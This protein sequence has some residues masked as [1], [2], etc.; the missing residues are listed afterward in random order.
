M[1]ISVVVTTLPELELAD[2]SEDCVRNPLC[3]H[4]PFGR[5]DGYA[6]KVAGST[7]D[8]QT[9]VCEA[10]NVHYDRWAAEEIIFRN[11]FLALDRVIEAVKAVQNTTSQLRVELDT[12]KGRQAASA[13][14]QVAQFFL[15]VGYLLTLAILYA[16]KKC[17]Q[18]RARQ[19]EEEVKL[20][21]EKLQERKA[22][23]RSA[24]ARAKSG[25]SPTQE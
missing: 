8:V 14:L 9:T 3:K 23:R 25:P 6:C 12:L 7:Q 20:M 22:K 18:H 24:A 1:S 11:T 17:R 10:L 15:F 19:M 5:S 4:S 2:G 16:V 21:E 13:A